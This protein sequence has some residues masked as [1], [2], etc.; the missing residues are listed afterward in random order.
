MVAVAILEQSLLNRVFVESASVRQTFEST[1]AN[2]R[3][4]A[5]TDTDRCCLNPLI[6]FECMLK[7]VREM[8]VNKAI[9]SYISF[10]CFA[11]LQARKKIN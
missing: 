2:I 11:L 6:N 9:I 3:N 4:M 5:G 7:L 10:V 8:C 1:S